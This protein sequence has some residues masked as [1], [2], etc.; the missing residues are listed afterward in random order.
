MLPGETGHIILYI[1]PVQSEKQAQKT[2]ALVSWIQATG[3]G[4]DAF[5][6]ADEVLV[7][8]NRLEDGAPLSSVD[9]TFW[10]G[11]IRG[12]TGEDGTALL[13]RPGDDE[14]TLIAR[15]GDD[16]AILPPGKFNLFS[17]LDMMV[18]LL[19]DLDMWG[20]F[21]EERTDSVSMS[22]TIVRFTAR[23]KRSA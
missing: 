19:S 5:V 4:L 17:H 3:I 9:L 20:G 12:T 7:W 23:V 22:L 8:A 16:V 6:D 15:L 13:P 1:E 14:G 11:N 21:L 10:P 2:E 18:G